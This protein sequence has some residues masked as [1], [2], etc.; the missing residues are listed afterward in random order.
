[1]DLLS[2]KGNDVAEQR[3]KMMSEMDIGAKGFCD[4]NALYGGPPRAVWGQGVPV[5]GT[6]LMTRSFLL[7]SEVFP[8]SSPQA[9]L[10]VQRE[11][12]GYYVR[13]PAGAPTVKFRRDHPPTPLPVVGTDP[14]PAE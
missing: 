9:A 7:D 12:M 8:E 10:F 4:V 1:M 3:P 6:A 14:Q 5:S 2:W 11:L 13:I